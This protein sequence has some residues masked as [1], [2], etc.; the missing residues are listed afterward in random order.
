[1]T[2]LLRHAVQVAVSAVRDPELGNVTIGDLGLVQSVDVDADGHAS[3]VLVPTFSGCPAL[4]IIATDAKTAA[5]SGGAQSAIVRFDHSVPWT[6]TKINADGRSSLGELGIAVA[7][8]G[9]AACPYCTSSALEPLSPV[10]P[11]ACRSVAW[12]T[13]CR[14]IVEIFRD[15]SVTP[16]VVSLPF[17]SRRGSY[18][19]L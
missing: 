5:V 12:C 4:N 10:G 17:P 1:M 8:D 14:N 6:T 15:S 3:V 16:V 18:V 9:I 7:T 11:A 19:H 13:D 2:E